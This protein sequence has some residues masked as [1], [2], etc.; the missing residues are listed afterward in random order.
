[1][2]TI[3]EVSEL[4]GV[5]LATVSRV[6]NGSDKVSEKTRLTV[7][8]AMQQLGY[9]PNT[10]AQSLASNRSNSVG[11]MVSELIGPFYGP[12]MAGIEH[13]LR[14]AHKHVI[15][16]AGHSSEQ[17]EIEGI[18]FLLSRRCDALILHVEAVSD[19]YLISLCQGP[20]PIVLLNRKIDAVAEHCISLNNHLGGYL[21]T[22]E[23]V[24]NG[25]R[26][27]ACITG[28]IWKRDAKERFEGYQQA[29]AEA[30]IAFD[31][32]LVAEGD[33][34]EPS[35]IAGMQKLLAAAPD[36][37]AVFC[38][39]DQ[40]A[41]GAVDVLRQHKLKIPEQVSVI[42]FDDAT[43]AYY[44]F[45]KLT[46]V[47]YPVQDMGEMAANWVMKKVYKLKTLPLLQVFEP[48]LVLR[49]SVS[50]RKKWK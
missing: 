27:I 21:A 8:K 31:A 41:S 37:T 5:S 45:P 13:R 42:G 50:K 19:D 36:L 38:G 12:M 7:E 4:A 11:V 17:D 29:L 33:F 24:R 48:Y 40:M 47:H 18:E 15:I 26:R 14:Q 1:M 39:N 46:T 34:N 6:I 10:I 49:D 28:P 22:Q 23:I 3:K 25:H 43:F 20:V 44:L 30:G 32:S 9:K 16:A 2:V 35:G